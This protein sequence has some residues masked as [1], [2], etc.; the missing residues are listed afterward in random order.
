M[1]DALDEDAD[2]RS[3][4]VALGPDALLSHNVA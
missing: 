3:H 1:N 4:L 2:I